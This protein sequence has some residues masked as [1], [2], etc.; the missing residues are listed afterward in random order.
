MNNV[1]GRSI[2]FNLGAQ[3]RSATG[4]FVISS[5]AGTGSNIIL[6]PNGDT[7][8]AGQLRVNSDGTVD[9]GAQATATNHAVRADRSVLSGTGLTGGGNLTADRTLA[10]T[11]QALALHN[12]ATNGLIARTGAG[13]VSGRTITAGSG[14]SVTDGN[15]VSGNP[16]IS[17]NVANNVTGSGA[18]ERV[19]IWSGTNTVTSNSRFTF[20][21]ANG[22]FVG[23]TRLNGTSDNVTS[24]LELGGSTNNIIR[25]T[26]FL[27]LDTNG[28]NERAR[29]LSTGE[30]LLGTTTELTGGGRLQVNGNVNC[31]DPTENRHAVTLGYL[32]TNLG[33]LRTAGDT[34]IGALRYAG[35]TRTAGQLYGSATNPIS[36]TRLN[37]DGNL[38]VTN[39]FALSGIVWGGE[40]VS[41]RGQVINLAN[42]GNSNWISSLN[43]YISIFTFRSITTTNAHAS[44]LE[45]KINGVLS[46]TVLSSNNV[47]VSIVSNG[48]NVQN[49][50]G[51]T[52]TAQV[53]RL[54]LNSI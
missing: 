4:A 16:T 12:L 11:G 45:T 49:V 8:T 23:P 42:N 48:V 30:V 51:S 14:I 39:L 33:A 41:S 26:G 46:I 10:L 52:I 53:N 36:T 34:G 43:D 24:I 29:I 6:R 40:I 5:A 44:V 50:S 3:I 15:G 21:D 20:V 47:N 37:Y 18:N 54:F 25:S 19:A 35:T 22:L 32:N 28:A 31:N 9:I 2:I 17:L 1:D 7:N 38:Y 27:R 13:T